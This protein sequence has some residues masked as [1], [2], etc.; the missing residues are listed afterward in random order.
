MNSTPPPNFETS[1]RAQLIKQLYTEQQF[2]HDIIHSLH[3]GIILFQSDFSVHTLNDRARV[4]LSFENDHE[5]LFED[6]V[7]FKNKKATRRFDLK[8]WLD[9]CLRSGHHFPKEH[10][11]WLKT[12]PQEPMTPL[13]FSFKPIFNDQDLVEQLLL[14]I[15]DHSLNA[16]VKEKK[17]ILNAALNSFDGQFITNDKGYI[18]SPNFAFCAYTGLMPE[19]L[20]SMTILNWLQQQVTLKVSEE[21]VLRCLLEDGRWSGELQVHPDENTTFYAVLSLSLICD[22][23]KNIECYVGTLQDI[24]DLKEAQA[25]MERLAFYDDLTGLPNRRL[26]LEHLEHSLLHHLRQRTFNAVLYLDLDR[27]KATNDAFGHR[28]GDELLQITAQR[29]KTVLRAED[30]VA[31]LGGDEFV[32]LAELDAPSYERAAQSALTLADKLIEALAED[33]LVLDQPVKN[34]ASIGICCFPLNEGEMAEDLIT[35]ADLAMYQAKHSGIGQ[36]RFYEHTLSEE[37]R[38]RHRLEKALNNAEFDHEFHLCFQPQF[39]LNEQLVSA[40]VLIR[41]QHPDLGLVSPAKF[42]PV[43]EDNR[44]IL[45]IGESVIRKAFHIAKQWNAQYHLQNLS[46]NISPIQ[47][48]ETSFVADIRRIQEEVGVNPSLI[49]LEITEGILITEMDIALRKIDALTEQG[50][51]FSI[52]D[53]GT[54]YSSLSYFQKLPIQELKIDRSF[55]FRVPESKEDIAIIE[56][57]IALANSKQLTIVAEGVETLDQVNHFKHYQGDMRLQGFYFSK[58]L[59][60]LEMEERFLKNTSTSF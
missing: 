56:T 34:C 55:V 20:C 17:R 30:T 45:K 39:D 29:L 53:F 60:Q 16:E 18:I 1:D 46:I 14:V 21:E 49:T 22:E 40:E 48:H 23:Q 25:E 44:Q 11:V 27:F 33:T 54:G 5:F 9:Q 32:I 42:I 57:I 7:L 10:P 26:F 58:P 51:K 28:A 3:D 43:A 15:Y 13:L 59:S 38:E 36:I 37:M 6:V 12:S 47:F 19:Q 35:Y 4:L 41:W 50:Y 31:R 8:R 24:T 2:R 52:D